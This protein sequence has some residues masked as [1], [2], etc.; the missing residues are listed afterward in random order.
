MC[1]SEAGV[2]EQEKRVRI[3]RPVRVLHSRGAATHDRVSEAQV[4]QNV[5]VLREGD[6]RV[7]ACDSPC[8]GTTE[9][10]TAG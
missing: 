8:L 5:L 9:E 1:S 4:G 10:N 2:E 6:E 7:S 3:I